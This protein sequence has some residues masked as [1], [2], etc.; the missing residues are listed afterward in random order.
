MSE[1]MNACATL[2]R[3]NGQLHATESTLHMYL[4]FQVQHEKYDNLSMYNDFSSSVFVFKFG[5]LCT[6]EFDIW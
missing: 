2:R 6:C 4:C 5:D 1:I 3:E